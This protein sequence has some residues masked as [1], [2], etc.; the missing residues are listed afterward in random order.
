MHPVYVEHRSGA[1]YSYVPPF[2]PSQHYPEYLWGA[3]C[4]AKA[5]NDAYDMV[6]EALRRL[7]L[8]QE[9]FG[10]AAWNPFGTFIV[11]GMTVLVKPNMVLNWHPEGNDPNLD[12]MITN[13]SLV[14]A[15][16]DYVLIALR[17]SGTVLVGDAPLQSC[18]YE[19]LISHMGYESIRDF[20]ASR[21]THLRY[22]DFRQVRSRYNEDGILET[23]EAPGD[24]LGYLLVD[25]GEQSAHR[26]IR[27]HRRNFRVTNYDH[28]KMRRYHTADNDSYLISGTAL[29]ADVI[30]T[31]PK[32]KTHRKAGMTASLKNFIG[33]I[34]HK[35]CLPHHRKGSRQE[36]GDEYLRP[37]PF[38]RLAV[39]LE[40]WFNIFS[41]A[42]AHWA[43]RQI[44]KGINFAWA[45]ARKNNTDPFS[46]G[47]WYGN[48]TIWRT[49]LDLVRIAR[50]ADKGGKLQTVPQR[51]IFGVADAIIAG[52][53]EGPLI[54]SRKEGGVIAVGFDLPALDLTLSALMGFDHRKLP[55]VLESFTAASL[56]LTSLPAD[57]V[58][59]HSN[60]PDWHGQLA[61][62]LPR[63]LSLMF[64]PAAGWAGHVEREDWAADS[65]ETP[66]TAAAAGY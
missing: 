16:V 63:R 60:H 17:G 39:F 26:D 30:I 59:I 54:A 3:E 1:T 56:P 25:M 18:D 36:G 52:E 49:T 41:I 29:S 58:A 11:P 34:G 37:N 35:D 2:H 64:T 27:Q 38:K 65:E 6:R 48:D 50:Y 66:S 12:T 40:E 14:R 61:T 20:Y 51:T 28:R 33:I 62:A 4:L 46:E 53:K 32:L 7:G 42:N 9:N 10:T 57:S 19:K 47:S 13:P 8:D 15:V 23:S 21:G 31:M 45:R 44:R 55:T 5:P 22:V 24:P 43:A